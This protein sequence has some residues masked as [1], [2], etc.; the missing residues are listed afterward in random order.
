V[1]SYLRLAEMTIAL[2][3]AAAETRWDVKRKALIDAK[4]RS[5]SGKEARRLIEQEGYRILDVRPD[6]EYK[7]V[8]TCLI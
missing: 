6:Y 3:V 5:V 1:L 4:V 8:C 2:S 7:E